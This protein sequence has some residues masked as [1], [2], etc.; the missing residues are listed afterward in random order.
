M[1]NC[2]AILVHRRRYYRPLFNLWNSIECSDPKKTKYIC[3]IIIYLNNKQPLTCLDNYSLGYAFVQFSSY[4]EAL[5]AVKSVNETMFKGNCF[6]EI[7]EL[8]VETQA[9][10][11]LLIG[12][13]LENYIS[14]KSV[15]LMS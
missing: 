4:F 8:V 6:Y 7:L 13:Y 14:L 11:L 5:E 9:D 2:L 3:S 1:I 15:T 12:W 10:I